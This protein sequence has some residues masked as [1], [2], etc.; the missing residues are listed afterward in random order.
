MAEEPQ[1]LRQLYEQ[2]NHE[3]RILETS[4]SSF[5]EANQQHLTQAITKYEQC[6]KVANEISLF[7]PNE[8]LEDISTPDLES[9]KFVLCPSSLNKSTK[10]KRQIF[11]HPL[12]PG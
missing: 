3:R 11:S 4:S 8:T 6:L 12:L 5:S 9:V 1:S 2:A 7:S 10:P